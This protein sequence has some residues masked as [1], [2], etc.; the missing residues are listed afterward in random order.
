VAQLDSEEWLIICRQVAQIKPNSHDEEIY[1]FMELCKAQGMNPFIRD[2]YLIKYGDNP[3]KTVTG[4]DF[5]VKRA[6]ANPR[7]KGFS[8]GII[9]LKNG[10]RI[11]NEG[12]LMLEDE[13]L[14]GGWAEVYVEGFSKPMRANASLTE[15]I[16]MK[17]GKPTGCWATMPAL[18]IRKIALVQ[19]LREAFP[20]EFRG[21]YDSAEMTDTYEQEGSIIQV[22]NVVETEPVIDTDEVFPTTNSTDVKPSKEEIRLLA[23]MT[24]GEGRY[25]G[26]K[27]GDIIKEDTAY[28]EDYIENG[29]NEVISEVLKTLFG[30]WKNYQNRSIP[31]D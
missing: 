4:K 15:H 22:E 18:M 8:A 27:L 25:R 21:L 31:T 5:F 9:V 20:D 7:Y 28:V 24:F 2:V 10:E 14:L 3:A 1:V 12:T 6:N 19:A 29:A 17:Y 30:I 26:R 23:N 11:Y 16:C 13:K